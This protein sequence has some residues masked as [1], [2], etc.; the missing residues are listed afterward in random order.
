[1]GA[2]IVGG[3]AKGGGPKSGELCGWE[4]CGWG[5]GRRG[6][7]R[8]VA[9]HKVGGPDLEKVEA[10]RVGPRR[11]GGPKISLFFPLS[12]SSFAFFSLGRV[13]SW[14]CGRGSRPS[15]TQIM[16]L[17]FSRVILCEPGRPTGRERG[18]LV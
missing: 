7:R 6:R 17:G 18:F 2:R 9:A 4:P 13:F 11:V 14:N 1:M 5:P 16:G 15:T 8:R 12:R 10:L 3:G